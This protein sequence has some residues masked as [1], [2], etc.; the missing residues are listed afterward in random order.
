M[1]KPFLFLWIALVVLPLRAQ[2]NEGLQMSPLLI[3]RS[4]QEIKNPII[5]Q[6]F[7]QKLKDLETGKR[8]QITIVQIGDSHVQGPYFPQYIR[9]GIQNKF[10]NAGRGFVFPYR[11]AGTNG[12]VDV[13]FKASGNWQAVRN[14]KSDGSDAIG[15]S[16]IYLETTDADFLMEINLSASLD[17]VSEIQIVSPHAKRFKLST[18]SQKNIL[19]KVHTT[20]TYHVKSGD[21]LGKIAGTFNTTVKKIQQANGMKNVNLRAGQALK[22]PTGLSENKL[23]S[24][25]TFSD[26]KFLKS[27]A[28]KIPA[29]IDQLY[30]RASKKESKYVLDGLLLNTNNKGV[31]FHGIGVNGTKFSDY[32]KF[33]R[34]FDQVAALHPDL[35]IISLGTNESFYD[36]YSEEKLKSDMDFFNRQMIQRGMTGSVLLTSPPPSM[37]N[38]KEINSTA[39]AYAYEMGVFANLNSWAFYDL[40]SV[41]RSS[42]AMPDWYEAKLTSGDKIHFLEKGYQ[43]QAELLVESLFN[44]FSDYNK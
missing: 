36:S 16:G 25:T 43:L 35:I 27:G 38:P 42:K 24:S 39:T 32:N 41:S 44:S 8:D 15:L 40:H 9:Q 11:V 23:A 19:E 30:V 20:R 2:K 22:I 1:I 31:I 6:D 17:T 29:G 7:F 3:D 21:Y 18:T 4:F 37:K 10:G 28:F 26:L 13:K 33:P 14:V 34:F 12:A 5:L